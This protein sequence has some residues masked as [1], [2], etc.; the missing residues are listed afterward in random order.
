MCV[1][2]HVCVC[3]CVSIRAGEVPVYR[4][5]QSDLDKLK[6]ELQSQAKVSGL[7]T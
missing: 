3:V 2:M 4:D 5:S 1:H 6:N 7:Y